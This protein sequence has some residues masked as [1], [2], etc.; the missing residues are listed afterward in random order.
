MSSVKGTLRRLFEAWRNWLSWYEAG[1]G[2]FVKGSIPPV[3]KLFA[4][5]SDHI[6]DHLK[7]FETRYWINH[8]I[9]DQSIDTDRYKS[10]HKT[11]QVHETLSLEA[12][13]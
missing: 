6:P 10:I 12:V 9:A 2:P 5:L 7:N 3:D 11:V 13:V 4:T 8:P 1:H